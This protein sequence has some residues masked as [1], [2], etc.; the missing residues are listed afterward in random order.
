MI[1]ILGMAAFGYVLLFYGKIYKFLDIVA[2]ILLFLG[3]NQYGIIAFLGVKIV[4]TVI[5][6]F[7]TPAKP[8]KLC[9]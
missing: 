4:L 3:V 6:P 1:G 2:G 5:I 8:M 7:T 9:I